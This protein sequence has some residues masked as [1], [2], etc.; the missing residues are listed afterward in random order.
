[1]S[2]EFLQSQNRIQDMEAHSEDPGISL[3]KGISEN[4]GG[5]GVGDQVWMWRELIGYRWE[6]WKKVA[7][8]TMCPTEMSS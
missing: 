2:K 3:W 5:V 1:M 8:W 4:C 7:R 6:N